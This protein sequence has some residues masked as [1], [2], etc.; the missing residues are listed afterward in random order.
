VTFFFD[1]DGTLLDHG[2]S[3]RSGIDTLVSFSTDLRVY[4][5]TELERL[6][7]EAEDQHF[8]RYE[9]GEISYAEQRRERL[10]QVFPHVCRD[11]AD[12]ALDSLYRE[13]LKGYEG[14][15]RLYADALPVLRA[16]AS[17]PLVLI[18][19]GASELQRSKIERLGLEAYFREILVSG[20]VGFAK[21]DRRIF[22]LAAERVGR[23]PETVSFVGDSI[24]ND[25]HGSAAAGMQPVWI[26][27]EAGHT[28]PTVPHRVIRSLAELLR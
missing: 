8:A 21:P 6:W 5:E 22:A 14:S 20:E 25:I 15:W 19:N 28:S 23:K 7:V 26:Q 13:Y 9:R 4:A 2:H 1:L 18:T 12:E 17:D 3:R 10:R 24:T 11:L 27:R 16:L